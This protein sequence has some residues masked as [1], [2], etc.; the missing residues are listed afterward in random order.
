M[1]AV[2]F[3]HLWDNFRLK[4]R[5]YSTKFEHLLVCHDLKLHYCS[6]T[7]VAYCSGKL[8]IVVCKTTRDS[9]FIPPPFLIVDEEK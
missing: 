5:S 2:L 9:L 1:H 4:P 3:L 7:T 6:Y 8:Y